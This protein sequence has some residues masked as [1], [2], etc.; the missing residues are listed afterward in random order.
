MRIYI[1][2]KLSVFQTGDMG[3]IPFIRLILRSYN[4]KKI[5]IEK[6]TVKKMGRRISW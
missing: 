2:G 1:S 5:D 6:I 3:S 4:T